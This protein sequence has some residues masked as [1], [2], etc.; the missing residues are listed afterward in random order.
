MFLQMG[1]FVDANHPLIKTGDLLA[2]PKQIFREHMSGRLA[3][4]FQSSPA[5]TA[6]LI[7]SLSDILSRQIVYPQSP[8]DKDPELGLPKVCQPFYAC[9][10]LSALKL[11]QHR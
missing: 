2:T 4:L 3:G 10:D 1:P 8:L 9:S 6:I 5:T 7:P 11:S